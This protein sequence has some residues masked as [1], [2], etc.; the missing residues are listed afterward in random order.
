MKKYLQ[1][2]KEFHE[3][4]PVEIYFVKNHLVKHLDDNTEDQTEIESILDYLYSEKPDISKIWYKTILEKTKKWHKKLQAVSS[5]DTEKAWEDYEIVKDFWDGFRFVKLV[6]QNSYNREGKLMSHCVASYYWRGVNIYSL[7]DSNNSPHCTIEENQQIKGKWNGKIDPKYVDYVVKFL[8]HLGMSIWENEMK[9]L[10]YYK[11]DSID[12]ELSCEKMYNWYVYEHNLELVKDKEW[13]KYNGFWLLNI[14]NIF[15]F[16]IDAKIKLK[17]NLD[18][19]SIVSYCVKKIKTATSGDS[20]HSATSGNCA[21]SATSGNSAHSATSG[22]YAHS[23]TSGN[24]AHSAT[25]GDESISC[26]IWYNWAAKSKIW[27]WIVLS[28][29]EYKKWKYTVLEVKTIKV[30]GKEVKEDTYYQLKK[31][32]FVELCS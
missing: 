4:N 21:H 29:I 9:N 14:K 15:S 18:I 25:S 23:A 16:D 20:S 26:S 8:E 12:K 1:L 19:K 17:W 13:I 22:D 31:G 24:Y 32:K 3:N 7:R 5:K 10:G 11:L 2:I 28:E 6:S 27:N 30:D